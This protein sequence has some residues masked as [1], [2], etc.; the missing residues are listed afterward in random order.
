MKQRVQGAVVGFAV[1]TLIMGGVSAV[2]AATRTIEATYGVNVVLDG[3]RQEFAD[4]M[5]PFTSDGRTF[6][7]LRAIADSLGLDVEW[8]AATSTAYL[9]SGGTAAPVSV[10]DGWS[11]LVPVPDPTLPAVPEPTLP[12]LPAPDPAPVP[13]P[14]PVA[15]PT[16]EPVPEPAPAPAMTVSQQNAIRSAETFINTMPFSRT[17]LIGQLEFG[18]FT[19]E[20]ATIAVDSITVDWYAQAVLSAE[21]FVALMPFSRSALIDQLLF[22]G[23]TQSQ[24]AHGATGVGL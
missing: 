13:E 1:A 21:S 23:F 7:P 15:E 4:D 20:E 9:T 14:A 5:Q 8:N 17:S 19:N 16:P 12:S 22:G 11:P 3:V 24:A 6:M 18:G 2:A 10:N